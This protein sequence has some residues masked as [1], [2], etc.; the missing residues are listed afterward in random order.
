MRGV[1]DVRVLGAI[2]VVELEDNQDVSK[3]CASLLEAGVWVRPFRS[4]VYLTPAFTIATEELDVLTNA[5]VNVVQAQP[6]ADSGG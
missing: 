2:G 3:M 6:G 5:I 4:V 1:R